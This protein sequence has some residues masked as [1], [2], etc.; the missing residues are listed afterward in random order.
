MVV[1]ALVAVRQTGGL[2]RMWPWPWR[3]RREIQRRSQRPRPRRGQK[4][5]AF[6]RVGYGK[7]EETG[8]REVE[9]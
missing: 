5:Q 2:Q 7:G 6:P 4:L 8:R 9:W 1:A 3:L